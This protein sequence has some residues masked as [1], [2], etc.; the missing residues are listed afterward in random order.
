VPLGFWEFYAVT[1]DNPANP[2][3]P[4]GAP[5]SVCELTCAAGDTAQA[6]CCA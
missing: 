2:A 3:D 5:T 4:Q 6:G 1:D